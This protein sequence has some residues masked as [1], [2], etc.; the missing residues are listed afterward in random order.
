MK[1]FAAIAVALAGLSA[2]PAAGPVAAQDQPRRVCLNST[3]IRNTHAVDSRTILFTMRNGD[4][5]RNTL[6]APCPSLVS[7]GAGSFTEVSHTD[8]ICAE[9]QHITVA[10]SG[11]VCRLGAFDRVK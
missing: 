10:V 7:Q 1:K 2:I 6:A 3:D 8:F 9:T 4:V 5:W 11:A